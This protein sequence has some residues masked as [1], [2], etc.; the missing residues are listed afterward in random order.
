[1]SEAPKRQLYKT[2]SSQI[3]KKENEKS[4]IIPLTPIFPASRIRLHGEG[5]GASR[6]KKVPNGLRKIQRVFYP[7][8]PRPRSPSVQAGR[9]VSNK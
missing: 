8:N 5:Y 3:E 2:P 9:I 7:L 4:E 1:L 6:Y